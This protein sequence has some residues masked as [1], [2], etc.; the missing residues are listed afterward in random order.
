MA[1]QIVWTQPAKLGLQ[2]LASG[3]INTAQLQQEI[4]QYVTTNYQ[5]W[6]DGVRQY[7]PMYPN[8]HPVNCSADQE[9]E[10]DETVAT[11]WSVEAD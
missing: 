2:S 6:P 1:L 7:F 9:T 3:G 5:S 4:N 11:V 10:D 8:N